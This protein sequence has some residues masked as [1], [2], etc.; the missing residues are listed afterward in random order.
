MGP[1]ASTTTANVPAPFPIATSAMRPAATDRSCVAVPDGPIVV[2]RTVL[3]TPRGFT[4]TARVT[5][6]GWN[7]PITAAH[8]DAGAMPGSEASSCA[9]DFDVVH[10]VSAAMGDPTVTRKSYAAGAAEPW[11]GTA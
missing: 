11:S 9:P 7:A 2:M 5:A 4:I 6:S 3:G 10:I 1:S 8:R